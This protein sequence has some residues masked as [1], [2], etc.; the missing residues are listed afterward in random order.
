MPERSKKGHTFHLVV[1]W[2]FWE[3]T[4]AAAAI[5]GRNLQQFIIDA[6]KAKVDTIEMESITRPWIPKG[7]R[8]PNE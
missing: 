8:R 1:P 5:D 7:L 6:M 3:R 4:K 2:D